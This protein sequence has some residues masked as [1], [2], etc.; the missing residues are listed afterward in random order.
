[1]PTET[2]SLSSKAAHYA[3]D[4]ALDLM[5]MIFDIYDS[6]LFFPLFD[7]CIYSKFRMYVND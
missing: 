7:L 2:S 6:S 3:V 5:V 4:A 1:M